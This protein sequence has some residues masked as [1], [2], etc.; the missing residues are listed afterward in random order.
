MDTEKQVKVG[1]KR[2]QARESIKTAK[3]EQPGT[4]RQG[5]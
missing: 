1:A 5:P 2:L 4:T 3:F